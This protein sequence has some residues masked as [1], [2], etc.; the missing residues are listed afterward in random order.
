MLAE[1][2]Q[3]RPGQRY[4][5]FRTIRDFLDR[6]PDIPRLDQEDHPRWGSYS[7]AIK[8][9]LR[10]PE[11]DL[12]LQADLREAL[13]YEEEEVGNQVGINSEQVELLPTNQIGEGEPSPVFQESLVADLEL[14]G[15][16]IEV[17]Q[18]F[19]PIP[20]VQKRWRK[21]IDNFFRQVKNRLFVPT[22]ILVWAINISAALG[23]PMLVYSPDSSPGGTPKTP[24]ATD[25]TNDS[26]GIYIKM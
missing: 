8:R 12:V 5:N 13:G 6:G 25:T 22:A 21:G 10:Q 7:N 20:T 2:V 24:Y 4:D 11:S 9:F 19:V 17:V 18:E 26:L 14:G 23:Y 16:G 15:G 1:S 3:W